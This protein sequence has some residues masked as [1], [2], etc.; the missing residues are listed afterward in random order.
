MKIKVNAMFC[1]LFPLYKKSK[2]VNEFNEFH[3]LPYLI[4]IYKSKWQYIL[5]QGDA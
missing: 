2:F 4:P 5:L 1:D 3:N